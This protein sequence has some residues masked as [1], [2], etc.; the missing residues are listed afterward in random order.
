MGFKKISSQNFSF[1]SPE[2]IE[3]TSAVYN[4]Q[5]SEFQ[6]AQCF[7][8]ISK[9]VINDVFAKAANNKTKDIR[10]CYGCLCS[11]LPALN[12]IAVSHGWVELG[13]VICD[14]SVPAGNYP[15]D[16]MVNYIYIK[17]SELT[18]EQYYHEVQRKNNRPDEVLRSDNQFLSEIE[19][20]G[21]RLLG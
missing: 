15:V 17:Q 21:Y 6:K 2:S 13:G 14:V 1:P 4:S 20:L 3:L 12:G 18:L 16:D 8:N 11:G 10:I 5:P 9:V 7:D 19:H